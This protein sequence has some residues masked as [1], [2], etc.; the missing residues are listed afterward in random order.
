MGHMLTIS[1]AGNSH[2]VQ[3]PS[4]QLGITEHINKMGLGSRKGVADED[5]FELCSS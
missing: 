5:H 3:T 4:K 2:S 1:T